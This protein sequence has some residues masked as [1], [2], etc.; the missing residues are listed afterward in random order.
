MTQLAWG[1]LESRGGYEHAGEM[2]NLL[3]AIRWGTDFF[4]RAHVED[5]V[6]FGMVSK[7]F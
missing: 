1:A 6:L 5:D 4:I 2:G 3:K 7:H